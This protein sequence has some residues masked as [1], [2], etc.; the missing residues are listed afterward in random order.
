MKFLSRLTLL[1]ALGLGLMGSA[2]AQEFRFGGLMMDRDGMMSNDMYTLSQVGFGFGTARSMA[3]AGAFTSLG[4]DLASMGINPAGLG[5][6]RS[7]DVSF[8]PMMG[9][10]NASNS[11]SRMATALSINGAL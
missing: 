11:A 3:M 6:Y 5:M 2:S 8:S 7:N 10:N 9:F 4:G 1:V